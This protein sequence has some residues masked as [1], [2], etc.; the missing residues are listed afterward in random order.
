M[1]TN[2]RARAWRAAALVLAVLCGGGFPL[3]AQEGSLAALQ[4][5]ANVSPSAV[6]LDARATGPFEYSTYRASDSLYVVEMSGVSLD[7]SGAPRV[8][9][10]DIVSGYRLLP[11][12]SLGHSVVRLEIL[13]RR[14]VA[15][16][17]ERVNAQNL[18]VTFEAPGTV[19]AAAPRLAPAA[20]SAPRPAAVKASAPSASASAFSLHPVIQGVT[21]D[22]ADGQVIV[23]IAASGKL[24]YQAMR[25]VKP[26]R[27]VLDFN[28]ATIGHL[29]K[30]ASVARPVAG[31]RAAQFKPDMAR[32]VI[33]LEH[34]APY[35]I[36]PGSTGLQ[37]TFSAPGAARQMPAHVASPSAPPV[38]VAEP[39]KTENVAATKAAEPAP[40]ADAVPA[41]QVHA[42]APQQVAPVPV[43]VSD[44]T[45]FSAPAV[46]VDSAAMPLPNALTGENAG[47]ASPKSDD[48]AS[49]SASTNPGA[50]A[51]APAAAPE[52]PAAA[53]VDPYPVDPMQAGGGAAK[54]YSGEPI[55]VNLKDVDLKDFF[56]LIHEISGLNVVLDPA[57]R[58]TLTLVLDDVPWDQALDIVLQNN[59]LDKQLQGNV[60]RIATKD[61]LKRE[62]ETARDLA[63]AQTE[64][65]ATVT[66]T[67]Q[68]SYA[69][70]S[71]LRDTLRRF[72]SSRGD[73][74]A[75]D[76]SNV[77]IIRDVPAVFPDMDA[78]IKVLDKKSQQVEI[79][80]RVVSASRSFSR[81]IGVQ[82]GFS[83]SWTNGRNVFGGLPGNPAFVSPIVRGPAL[84]PP[85]LVAAGTTQMP[86]ITNYPANAPNTGVSYAFSSPNAAVDLIIT[87]A[88]DRG[89][90]KLL[91]RPKIVTQNNV[92]GT[93][94]QGTSIPVQTVINNTISTQFIDAVLQLQVTPQITAEGTVFLTVNVQNNQPD[95]SR[96]VGGIPSIITESAD[97]RVLANDGGT[98]V[99]GGIILSTQN[100]TVDQ[101]PLFGSIPLIGHL[102]KHNLTTTSASE[103][104]FFI[105]PRIIPS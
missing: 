71:A 19:P 95:F 60:L 10:S 97:T 99:I 101:T 4:V 67:R 22:K 96:Q 44:Q 16:R 74:L 5:Q 65:V 61:T 102:F 21:L 27:L 48:R 66:A 76:R 1:K 94:K 3:F 25:L 54:K 2:G 79:E 86:F 28:G 38:A 57:V 14:P 46:P 30:P 8:L 104:L 36:T 83:G 6:T 90:G 40:A 18:I 52:P 13:L 91:S 26:D 34:N 43:L 41:P 88:E 100:T 62:A 58:G 87:A 9:N 78:L 64:A 84:P 63:K 29:P 7:G 37:V 20:M 105:T 55:S 92:M 32:I 24:D 42:A 85:P 12:R 69:K 81:E 50:P 77:L 49:T 59:N 33:D 98:V 11:Y 47:L 56:R 45:P 89:V 23:R 82:F 15:P 53:A 51:P 70:A 80:A 68:L 75:D 103:L 17:V 93:V 72:L 73:I 31:I 35:E 39:V